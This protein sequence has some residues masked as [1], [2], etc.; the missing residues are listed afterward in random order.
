LLSP[1]NRKTYL[2]AKRVSGSLVTK[3]VT[4]RDLADFVSVWLRRSRDGNGNCRAWFDLDLIA[5]GVSKT[6]RDKR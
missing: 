1:L 3:G 4:A 6:D 2:Y 5:K